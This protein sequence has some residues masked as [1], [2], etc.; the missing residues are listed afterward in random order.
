MSKSR[1]EREAER[2][3][4]EAEREKR[5]REMRE[6][7]REAARLREERF[8]QVGVFDRISWEF[9]CDQIWSQSLFTAH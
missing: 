6:E 1:E 4:K 2:E 9:I 8:A 3:K 5:D 7:R